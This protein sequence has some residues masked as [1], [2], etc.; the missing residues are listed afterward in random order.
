MR[1]C[2]VRFCVTEAMVGNTVAFSFFE[3]KHAKLFILYRA[4]PNDRHRP[5]EKCCGRKR[6]SNEEQRMSK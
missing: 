1:F 3:N 5:L 4:M 6:V 2:I